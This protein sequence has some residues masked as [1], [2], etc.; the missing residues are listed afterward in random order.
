MKYLNILFQVRRNP[1]LNA[2]RFSQTICLSNCT[3]EMCTNLSSQFVPLVEKS[4]QM[5]WVSKN[6]YN[7]CMKRKSPIS[8]IYVPKCLGQNLNRYLVWMKSIVLNHIVLG[9][10]DRQFISLCPFQTWKSGFYPPRF[11]NKFFPMNFEHMSISVSHC[12]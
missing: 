10:N 6:T 9:H 3:W 12:S 11:P 1:A 5:K 8:V 4:I 2:I 7:V